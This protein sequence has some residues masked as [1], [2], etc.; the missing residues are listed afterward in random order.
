MDPGA[1]VDV[2]SLESP[3]A[4][5]EVQYRLMV[6]RRAVAGQ[7]GCWGGTAI[8]DED[9]V[10]L[11]PGWRLE[12]DRPTALFWA[13]EKAREDDHFLWVWN[14]DGAAGWV[15]PD[16][17]SGTLPVASGMPGIRATREQR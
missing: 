2:P 10:S 13:L 11:I 15:V 7:G 17:W 3:G 6:F 5:S 1:T 14:N 4:T 8:V 16:G 9:G 12:T